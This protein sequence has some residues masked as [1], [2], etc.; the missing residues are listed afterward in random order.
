[1]EVATLLQVGPFLKSY[2]IVIVKEM[3]LISS[4]YPPPPFVS[5]LARAP[6]CVTCMHV[7]AHIDTI[8][9]VYG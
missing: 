8:A 3:P 1:M 2:H 9:I 4:Q 5:V 7:V 6:I